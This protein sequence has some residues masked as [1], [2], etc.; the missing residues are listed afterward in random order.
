LRT[1]VA[2]S[3]LASARVGAEDSTGRV[4]EFL[5][6]SELLPASVFT[7][8]LTD[9]LGGCARDVDVGPCSGALIGRTAAL[10]GAVR[11]STA[12]ISDEARCSAEASTFVAEIFFEPPVFATA[13]F[14][15]VARAALVF[16]A[17]FFSAG[18]FTALF[19]AAAFF[20]ATFFA[21]LFLAPAVVFAA[22]FLRTAAFFLGAAFFFTAVFFAEAAFFLGAAFFFTALFLLDAAF[23]FTAAFLLDATFFFAVLRAVVLARTVNGAVPA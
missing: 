5:R 19:F 10:R 4:S 14:A 15:T 3:P 7:R 6:F 13:F 16:A 9:A 22:D 8:C 20:G 21:A 2:E 17:A 12:M 18:F 1:G 23:F 11:F